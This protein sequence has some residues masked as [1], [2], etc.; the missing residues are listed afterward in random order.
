MNWLAFFHMIGIFAAASAYAGLAVWFM[1]W[2]EPKIGFWSFVIPVVSLFLAGAV[3]V[4][5]TT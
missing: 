3:Y 2:A 4:G 5:L 1:L